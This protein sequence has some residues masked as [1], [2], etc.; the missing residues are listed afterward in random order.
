MSKEWFDNQAGLVDYLNQE[1]NNS[2]E[3]MSFSELSK[4]LR[5]EEIA[6]SEHKRNYG[7]TWDIESNKSMKR[8]SNRIRAIRTY[9]SKINDFGI[10]ETLEEEFRRR[11]RKLRNTIS[12][13]DKR[14]NKLLKEVDKYKE[15]VKINQHIATSKKSK[16]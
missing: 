15:L 8:C 2:Y 5:K 4:C 1:K 16:K 13:R 14:I 9:M 7:N 3:L 12:E 10:N 11:E 6:L